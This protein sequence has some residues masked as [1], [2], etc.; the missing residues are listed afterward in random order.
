MAT[1]AE[2]DRELAR[3][4]EESKAKY[5]SFFK[6]AFGSLSGT[7]QVSL[8]N[9]NKTTYAQFKDDPNLLDFARKTNFNLIALG[10]SSLDASQAVNALATQQRMQNA[11]ILRNTQQI[12][13]DSTSKTPIDLTQAGNPGIKEKASETINSIKDTIGTT[14]ILILAGV[15]IFTLVKK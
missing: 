11:L 1:K 7:K 10:Q 5:P 3:L 6:T 12:A 15:V 2:L 9:A 4:I 8:A 14:G 13:A